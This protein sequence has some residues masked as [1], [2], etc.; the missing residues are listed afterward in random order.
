MP[1]NLYTLGPV[2]R[3]AR[4]PLFAGLDRS[5]VSVVLE[6][7]T[8]QYWRAGETVLEADGFR[9]VMYVVEAGMLM[10]TSADLSFDRE[11]PRTV[12]AGQVLGEQSYLCGELSSHRVTCLLPSVLVAIDR[13]QMDRLA[14]S[15]ADIVQ[16]FTAN[17]TKLL[18]MRAHPVKLAKAV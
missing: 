13:R 10:M 5:A 4:A 7:S 18:L 9:P 12:D 6:A 3:L 16:R 17:A 11:P 14:N 1:E 8:R 15:H 2:D